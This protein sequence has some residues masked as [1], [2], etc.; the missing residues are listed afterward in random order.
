MLRLRGRNNPNRYLSICL[1]K[2]NKKKYVQI[3]R[4]VAKYFVDGYFHG[5]VVNHKDT[6]IHNNNYMNLEWITQ[7]RKHT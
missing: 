2:N 4:L 6:N 1:C 7:K 5:A 3:H